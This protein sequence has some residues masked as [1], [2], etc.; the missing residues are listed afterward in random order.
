LWPSDAQHTGLIQTKPDLAVAAI[1][2]P[3]R[4]NLLYVFG[5]TVTELWT[6]TG[7]QLFPYERSTSINIDYGCINQATIAFNENIV[8]WLA[9]NEKSGPAIMMMTGG[10]VKRIS[11]DGIDFR[12]AQLTAPNDSYGFLFR[13]DGHLLYQIT[14]PTDNLSYV[15]DFNTQMFFTLCD[16]NM[17]Y[18]IAK[19]VAFFNDNYYFVS[20]N[21]GNVYRLSS[22]ITTFDGAEV[23]RI[24]V[25]PAFRLPD[26][27][28]FIV[29]SLGFTLEQG[30]S[31][32]IERV[33]LSV[34]RDGGESFGNSYGVWMNPLGVR[35]NKLTY[36][37]LGY[38]NDFTPQFRF[39]GQGRFV[40]F[41]GTLEVSQ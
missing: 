11:N 8:V 16:P 36:W 14:F 39:W 13:Q 35:K 5:E 20:I 3:G 28:N 6:D 10:D 41:N 21:D 31:A 1:P 38:A 18:H 2:A 37:N 27:S 9:S 29:N 25:C 32:D 26:Q 40:A 12:L 19:R 33:D 22:N 15:Y 23:P 17:D 4:G 24:R 34:S 30:I 7:A